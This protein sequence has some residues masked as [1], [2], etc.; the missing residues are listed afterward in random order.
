MALTVWQID[1]ANMTFYYNL[2]FCHAL[3]QA[4]CEVR[5]ITT[6]F[7]YDEGLRFP[8][9]FV[10]DNLY[11]RGLSHPILLKLPHMR[12]GLRALSYPLGHRALY[13]QARRVK[14]DVIHFQWSRL[15]KFDICLISQ[16]QALGIPVVHT[17]HDV[18]PLFASNATDTLGRIYAQSDALM[19]HTQANVDDLLVEFPAINADHIHVIPHLEIANHDVP[20][21]ASLESARARLG[22]PQND[23]VFLF[24]GSIKRYKGIDILLEAFEHV[25]KSVPTVQL[26]ITGRIDPLEFKS[27]PALEQLH[28]H[29]NVHIHDHFIPHTEL[30]AHYMAADVAVYPYR[31]IYQSGAMI[32]A[33]GFKK[34]IISSNVGG[35]SENI[36]GNGWLVPKEDVQ[37][38]T[39]VLIQAAQDREQLRT[40]GERSY[41]IIQARYS[42]PVVAEQV[43]QMYEALLKA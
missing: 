26:V 17:V 40:M 15:P 33:M 25:L 9:S 42:G 1:A 3:A 4:G 34:A 8:D 19:V 2:A 6:R 36:D 32:T 5:Y 43:I 20:H 7:L 37:A 10:T 39:D 18:I 27:L 28:D 30:W 31:H 21:N 12:R 11:F 23:P 29:P 38:L 35:L 14:P 24:F 22:L 13:R 41:E 16:I